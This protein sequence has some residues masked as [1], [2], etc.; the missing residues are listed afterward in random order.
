MSPH[1]SDNSVWKLN[2][3]D[4]S[5]LLKGI[6]CCFYR[7]NIQYGWNWPKVQYVLAVLI[8]SLRLL[9]FWGPG[10]AAGL[11]SGDRLKWRIKARRENEGR[12]VFWKR[13]AERPAVSQKWRWTQAERKLS[14]TRWDRGWMFEAIAFKNS[15]KA[16]WLLAAL[17][18]GKRSLW[19]VQR[20]VERGG[21][22]RG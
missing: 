5:A 19:V 1:D 14:P 9:R 8:V 21:V 7:R 22:R 18:N 3:D 15:N 4:Q 6:F 13:G 20:P 12:E 11:S 17:E 16:S 10:W 2:V